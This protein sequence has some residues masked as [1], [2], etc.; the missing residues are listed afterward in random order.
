MEKK[1]KKLYAVFVVVLVCVALIVGVSVHYGT[2][3]A[4][5]DN[6]KA[7]TVRCT[8]LTFIQCFVD[9]Q[10]SLHTLF[11]GHVVKAQAYEVHLSCKQVVNFL[12]GL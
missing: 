5:S 9:K 8:Y 12:H 7:G 1:E 10:A 6:S 4:N 3:S 11:Y 2:K